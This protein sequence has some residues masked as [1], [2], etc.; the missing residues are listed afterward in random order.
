RRAPMILIAIVGPTAVG[1]TE[2]AVRLAQEFR[3]EIVSADSRQI[4]RGMDIATAKPTAEEMARVPHHL[5]D[6]VNPDEGFTLAEYQRRAYAAID[7]IAS[8]GR[9]PLL[10][11]GTG[12]YVRS[13]VEGL[14][15]PRVAPNAALRESLER[16]EAADLY[17]RLEHLD[18]DA[19][20][21]ILP[22][23]TRRIIRALEV[24][25]ATGEPISR[26]QTRRPPPYP[27]VMIGLT[28]PREELYG[29]VDRRID[30][31]LEHGLIDEVRELVEHG[32]GFDLPSMTS[33]GY[34][35]IG[36]YLQSQISLEEAIRLFKSNTRK[37]IRH[38]YNWF[39]PTDPR[40]R[41]FDRSVPDEERKVRQF[42]AT[43]LERETGER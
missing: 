15:I 7:E 36:Q 17:A 6:I 13:V 34:R 11:G 26:Q 40:I 35:E 30:R 29:R 25:H 42:A 3:G 31:M 20:A 43:S 22:G 18:P 8:R 21:R 33:L 38:Q 2:I 23:N 28:M 39:R 9:Q 19:A 32:Y 41:W 12:L 4:Y 24:I 16:A 37:F 10:V 27:V 14:Q 5:V 1:K